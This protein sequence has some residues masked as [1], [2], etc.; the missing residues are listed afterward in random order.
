M[1][2]AYHYVIWLSVIAAITAGM[3]VYIRW[4][5]VVA[6][7][8]ARPW[9]SIFTILLIV[10]AASFPLTFFANRVFPPF[11]R[12][13]VLAIG[14]TW[15]GISFLLFAGHLA[16][17]LPRLFFGPAGSTVSRSITWSTTG[18][19]FILSVFSVWNAI[20]EPAM[21]HLRITLP[22]LPKSLSG[23]TILQISDI[24]AGGLIPKYRIR[25]ILRNA[26]ELKPDLVAITGDL[27]DGSAAYH[28]ETLSMIGE[29]KAKY[30]VYFVTGNHEYYSGV[31]EWLSFL[32]NL[33]VRV[34][35]NERV[36]IGTKEA[37]FDLAGV[38][39]P[40]GRMAPGHGTDI[41]KAMQ[42][43]DP[44]RAVVLLSHNPIQVFEA[45][46]YDVGLVLSGH[47]HNGQ[48]WPFNYLVKIHHPHITGVH[49]V[50]NT[51]LYISQG[52]GF[53][54]PPM[55]FLTRGEMT[56]VELVSPTI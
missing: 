38:D 56:L 20:R 49:H 12:E 50:G 23:T 2:R 15:L 18:A 51:E 34:L 11:W 6:T 31:E 41:P 1:P 44:G 25:E 10:L 21:T 43:R 29:L 16:V 53:W 3:H 8:M 45:A 40:T 22:Y 28:A 47:T 36:A 24:H 7:D 32:K 37:S 27:V 9:R 17:E 48:I 19:V 4:R 26:K 35:R 52:T 13:I 46:K 5:L 39:D 55:R 14:F 54:G 33:G 42:G 30:G